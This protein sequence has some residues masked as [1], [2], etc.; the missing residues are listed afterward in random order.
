MGDKSRIAVLIAQLARR[1][2]GHVTR[3]QLLAL[4]LTRQAVARRVTTGTLIPMYAGVYAVGH[5]QNT[6]IAR[7]HAAVLACGPHALL[8]HDSACALWGLGRWPRVPEV[9]VSVGDGGRRRPGLIVHRTRT[10]RPGEATTQLGVRTTSAARTIADIAPRRTDAQ[11]TRAVN[12]A[13]HDSHLPRHRLAE[14]LHRC[15]RLRNLIEPDEAPTRSELEDRFVAWIHKHHLPMP[16]L[17]V[18]LRD[19][20]EVDAL[21]E[22][23]K[24]IIEVDGWR[25]H[26][27][28]LAF[29]TDR[30][31]DARHLELGYGTHRL[32][33]RR[34]NAAEARRVN[35]ILISRSSTD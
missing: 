2:H 32:T 22:A 24:L 23:Q 9:T 10:L 11:L 17:N 7:A 19:G 20:D 27:G 13:R 29:E 14:L 26:G 34:L 16:T 5:A 21:Y 30:E 18:R 1:Q 4:G 3:Q 15:P 35:N 33:E 8:S 28:R 25:F 31:R 12:Q 6:P